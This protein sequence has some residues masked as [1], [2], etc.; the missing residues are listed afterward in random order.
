LIADLQESNILLGMNAETAKLDL[1]NYEQQEQNS[2]CARKS[3]G[4][5]VIYVSRRLVPS[6]Y[7]YGLPVLCDFG[8]ARLRDY[9][10]MADIQPYQYRAP[11]VIF[12]IPWDEKVDIWNVGVMV[13]TRIVCTRAYVD[14][15]RVDLGPA[16]KRKLISHYWRGRE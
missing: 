5:R 6:I 14:E 11:E 10:N 15:G 8:E 1:D 12:E 4:E 16:R 7:S 13:R 3:D 9:D 2:P